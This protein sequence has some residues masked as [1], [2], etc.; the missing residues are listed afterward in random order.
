MEVTVQ[1]IRERLAEIRP[2]GLKRD[3]VAAGLI[4]EVRL[5]EQRV[6]IEM[7][8]G[9]LPQP[10]IDATVE[11]IRRSVGAF[12]GVSHVDVQIAQAA[13]PEIGPIPG[14]ASIVAVSSTKGGVGKSTVAANLA[15]ALAA[16]G[17][18][19]GLLDA[20]VYGP[21][22]PTMLGLSE[23]PRV[24]GEE[25]VQPL[26]AH[27]VSFISMGLFV[28][29]SSPVI[30]RGPLV[31][32]VLRQFL[33]DV[34]WGELDV[35]LVDL[36]PGTGDVQLTLVQQVPV[37][38]A[39]VVTTPQEVS[40]ID[41]ERGVAM[42]R[43]VNTPVFGIVENMSGF[44]CSQCGEVDALFGEGGGEAL[45]GTFG[46][47]LLAKIPIVEEVRVAGD[48]GTP[49]VVSQPEHAVSVAYRALAEQVATAIDTVAQSASTPRI[50]G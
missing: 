10:V 46:V 49:L 8:R 43:Q 17:K 32:G 33:K 44:V 30:W 24:V 29:D 47:P 14:V 35:L 22:M 31:T 37:S 9:P 23:R 45:A 12:D 39:V 34:A 21:S 48:T 20:D 36:P 2:A 4:R 27:G 19:V 16:A 18:R 26:V 50:V 13:A 28:D 6:H 40:L 7:M 41:V 38:G 25:M 15:C 11:E 5:V 1:L 3:I 42:F